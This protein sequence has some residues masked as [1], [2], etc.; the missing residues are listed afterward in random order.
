MFGRTLQVRQVHKG[1]QSKWQSVGIAQ[2]NELCELVND[3]TES[4][5]ALIA[6]IAELKE[7]LSKL[8]FGRFPEKRKEFPTGGHFP[9]RETSAFKSRRDPE[10]IRAIGSV[11]HPH[12]EPVPG[13]LVVVNVTDPANR[14]VSDVARAVEARCHAPAVDHTPSRS[15]HSS[16]SHSDH[17]SSSSSSYSDSS[18]S[19]SSYSDSSSSSSSSCD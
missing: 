5:L 15:D 11:G 19:S 3:K 2:I 8:R 14:E 10:P 4:N 16:S 12:I 7:E 6:E 18:S 9:H 1:L 17:G 13:T